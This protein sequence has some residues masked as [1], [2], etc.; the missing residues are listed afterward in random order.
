[1]RSLIIALCIAAQAAVLAYM[2]FGRE[3]IIATGQKVTIATAP[4]DPRDPFRGDFV[5][6]KY[7]MNSFSAAPTRWA[8]ESYEPR[9]GDRIYAILKP[10]SSGLYELSYFTNEQ[11]DG[12]TSNTTVYIR[13]RVQSNRQF[14]G[15]N[16]FNAKFG[17]EQLYVQ[18]GAG[19][20]IEE[21]RGI[22][23]GMQTAMEAEIAIGKNGTAVLTDYR[24]SPLGILLEV[25]DSF[26]LVNDEQQ[27]NATTGSQDTDSQP[28]TDV[29]IPPVKIQVQNLSDQSI[30]INNP[31]D[32]CGFRLEPAMLS[33]SVFKEAINSCTGNTDEVPYTLTPGQALSID[34]NLQDTRWHVVLNNNEDTLPGDIRSFTQYSELFRV[35]YRTPQINEPT[36]PSTPY[37]QGDLVSQ[38]FNQQ[39]WID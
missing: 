23:G 13:G 27:S 11:P 22:R 25:T 30:T 4:I 28:N 8:P 21:R 14:S 19:I 18:Q 17:V 35:V 20:D 26:T 38:A 3:H 10:R 24:W 9:K 31:G 36:D 39:G 7:P 29:T 15:R 2:V 33:N 6:L 5:R 37:W 34:I 32:N 12:N 1:M 16:S